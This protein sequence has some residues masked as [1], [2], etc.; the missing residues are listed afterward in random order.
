MLVVDDDAGDRMALFRLLER[1]G[2]HATVA[3]N[4]RAALD[5]LRE[6]PFDVVLID[7]LM[8][9]DEGFT[10]LEALRGEGALRHIPVIAMSSGDD[11]AAVGRCLELGA[12]DYIP[13]PVD[14]AVLRA[15]INASLEKTRL[16]E[17]EGEYLDALGHVARAAGAVGT[18]AFDAAALDD[19]ARRPDTLGQLARAVRKVAARLNEQA[20]DSRP[21]A[22]H[23]PST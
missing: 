13:K 8:P 22:Q 4:G 19:V 23:V 14:P 17:R 5:L 10:V 11:T 2:H 21:G 16:R 7:L 20:V 18:D 3:D 1:D 12:D 9:D 6:E 15:R